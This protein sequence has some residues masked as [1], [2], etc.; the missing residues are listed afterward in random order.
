MK[1]LKYLYR[2]LFCELKICGIVFSVGG[3]L[4]LMGSFLLFGLGR[5]EYMEPTAFCPFGYALALVG[6]MVF[7]LCGFRFLNRRNSADVYHSIPCS[8]R[9]LYICT[10]GA[11]F[12][13]ITGLMAAAWLLSAAGYLLLGIRFSFFQMIVSFLV[14]LISGLMVASAT[15]IAISIS[16]TTLSALAAA[17]VINF[18]PRLILSAIACNLCANDILAIDKLG[19]LSSQYN[20]SFG[21]WLG[22]L[23]SSMGSGSSLTVDKMLEQIYSFGTPMLY[24]L[25]LTAVYLVLGCLLFV[26]RKSEAAGNSTVNGLTQHIIRCGMAVPFL[27]T[28]MY[29]RRFEDLSVDDELVWIFLLFA[30]GVYAIYELIT[31]RKF[32]KMLKSIPLFVGVTVL[33]LGASY[34]AE[35]IGDLIAQ[36]TVT[37]EQIESVQFTGQ[38]SMYPM[39]N[40]YLATKIGRLR[41]EQ[42]EVKEIIARGLAQNTV[43]I[44]VVKE[45]EDFD[46][47][48][49]DEGCYTLRTVI[50]SSKGNF[51][52]YIRIS[53]KDYLRLLKLLVTDEKAL[54]TAAELPAASEMFDFSI[55]SISTANT[56]LTNKELGQVWDCAVEEYQSLS[57]E[58]KERYYASYQV[59]HQTDSPYASRDTLM[60]RMTGT[61]F[62]RGRVSEMTFCVGSLLPKTSELFF[63]MLNSEEYIA[64]FIEVLRTNVENGRFSESNSST[65]LRISYRDKNGFSSEAAN[66][67]WYGYPEKYADTETVEN[68]DDPEKQVSA[69]QYYFVKEDDDIFEVMKKASTMTYVPIIVLDDAAILRIAD[70]L[71]KGGFTTPNPDVGYYTLEFQSYGHGSVDNRMLYLSFPQQ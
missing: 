14:M 54:Q 18:A 8:R 71:E 52:R 15:T 55:S 7:P 27:V 12:T 44:G 31:G 26:R 45:D 28:L 42:P 34:A 40:N 64:D 59:N 3:L 9:Q 2:E 48:Y 24:S 32:K 37:A 60:F 65:S 21:S 67:G 17:L 36:K 53:E 58:D 25:L 10:M 57:A 33:L 38:T 20:L 6:G 63:K 61:G 4:M 16:G 47:Y 46:P 39:D 1:S 70:Q 43:D 56:H 62:C 19:I 29:Y 5:A 35:P 49:Y 41:F 11:V 13:W 69:D 66:A 30:F 22:L 68:I 23:L 51:T 50:R